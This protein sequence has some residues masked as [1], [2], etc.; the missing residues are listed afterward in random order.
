VDYLETQGEIDEA[1][2]QLAIC[3]NDDLFVSP[4]GTTQGVCM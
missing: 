3:V 2:H 1:A 4:K